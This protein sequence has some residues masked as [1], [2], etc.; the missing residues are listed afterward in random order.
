MNDIQDAGQP[1]PG[2]EL[3]W[4]HRRHAATR[5]EWP[6]GVLEACEALDVE[7]DEFHTTWSG[8]PQAGAGWPEGFHTIKIGESGPGRWMHALDAEGA[9]TAIQTRIDDLRQYDTLRTRAVRA[10]IEGAGRVIDGGAK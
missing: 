1:K 7:F 4:Q 6:E 5:L 2:V 9:R 8:G 10:P 3:M